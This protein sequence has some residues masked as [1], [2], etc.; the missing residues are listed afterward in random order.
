MA[1]C[2]LTLSDEESSKKIDIDELYEKRKNRDL[3]QLSIFNKILNRI[4]RRILLTGKT[5]QNEKFIWFNVPEY[6]FGEPIY[7]KGHCIAYL[8]SKLEENG[9]SLKYL[10]PN[11]L[12]VSWEQWVPSYVR[13]EVKKKTG[14]VLDE[15]GN[16]VLTK[17]E[18]EEKEREREREREQLTQK[19]IKQSPFTPIKKYKPTGHL[20]YDNELFEKIEKKVSFV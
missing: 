9:F 10:H 12:F 19:D 5:K 4:H 17:K 6:I 18:E 7:D 15:R 14:I 16:T 3:K 2:F 13:T 8:F 20:V 1:S 11:T